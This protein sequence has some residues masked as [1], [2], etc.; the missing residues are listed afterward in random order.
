MAQYKK[1]YLSITEQ[2]NLLKT[3]G[4]EISD[5]QKAERY[6]NH[7]GYYRLSAYWY[8]CRE[9]DPSNEHVRLDAFKASTNFADVVDLYVFDKR[10]R[11]LFLDAIERIEVS[12]RTAIA[13]EIGAA[14]PWA[15][16]D[17]KIYK[18][19]FT[20]KP[21]V[22]SQS[23]FEKWKNKLSNQQVVSKESFVTHFSKKYPKSELPIWIAVELWDFGMLS[24]L[25][26]GLDPKHSR[27]ISNSYGVAQRPNLVP[28]WIRSLNIV[29]N[30]CAH[31]ARLWNRM[32]PFEVKSVHGDGISTLEHLRGD[33]VD[34][35]RT[36]AAA[37]VMQFL[38][39]EISSDSSWSN[40]LS[41]LIETFPSTDH[42]RLS[43]A[44][45]PENWKAESLW[46]L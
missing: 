25:L 15:Y 3:R 41:A 2:I 21:G 29:R 4:M 44:G 27:A 18:K 17:P 24:K 9:V 8:P 12:L 22:Q 7:I 6:L 40:R 5:Q 33:D 39:K 20:V 32:S 10:L 46:G 23:Q 30:I 13:L 28:A 34:R 26:S 1:P 11:L 19:N 45:F 14:S 43:D 42:F 38:M 31:H 35:K 36:Y 16:L 37:A